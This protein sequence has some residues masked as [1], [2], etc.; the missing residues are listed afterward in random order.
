[1]EKGY[2]K[3]IDIL[4]LAKQNDV[5]ILLNGDQLQ[6]K[7]PKGKI[8][9]KDLLKELGAHKK[10]IID[11]LSSDGLRLEIVNDTNRKINSF[12]RDAV[13]YIP[14]SFSQE[15]LWFI[16]RLEGS[17]QYHLPTVLRLRGILDQSALSKALREIM[18]R[19]EILRTV[20]CEEEDGLVYQHVKTIGNWQ[21]SESDGSK[22]VDHSE[23][24]EGYIQ[25]L[26]QKP[27]DLSGDYMLRAELIKLSDL[28]HI[29]VVTMHHIASDGWSTSVLVKEVMALYGEY[30]AGKRL[31]Y[32]C[33]R[34]NLRIMHF[35]SVN[36]CRAMC[37]R[38][39][40]VTGSRSWTA[41]P[42]CNCR[43]ITIVRWFKVPVG[44]RAALR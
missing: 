41:L 30:T 19:H 39:S 38:I 14:L 34:C 12:D 6:L 9:D 26:T 37:W 31:N 3:A 8:I 2:T 40:W 23:A 29:L 4:N 1:M 36:T 27:F 22:Y 24:L 16:D 25:E 28:E 20:Y 17:V 18:N 7:V 21:L 33:Y 35:G 43:L 32:Q 42:R 11:F 5:D 10:L 44:P 15:R 13:K